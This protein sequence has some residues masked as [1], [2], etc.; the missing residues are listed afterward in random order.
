M[1]SNKSVLNVSSVCCCQVPSQHYNLVPVTR[2]ENFLL[3]NGAG[4]DKGG[5]RRPKRSQKGR[6]VRRE[7]K[8]EEKRKLEP[9]MSD[10]YSD[11]EGSVGHKAGFADATMD[12]EVELCLPLEVDM[13]QDRPRKD[14]RTHSGAATPSA[15]DLG[16]E[17]QRRFEPHKRGQI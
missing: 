1:F 8:S 12:M 16:Q 4:T 15:V 13:D 9:E 2:I 10:D 7:E 6:E 14:I 5:H 11:G 17:K 3:R